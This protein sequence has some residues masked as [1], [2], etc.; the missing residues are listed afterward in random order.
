MSQNNFRG[1]YKITI[2]RKSHDVLINLNSLRMVCKDMSVDF[3]DLQN[4]LSGNPFDSVPAIVYYSILNARFKAKAKGGFMGYE[5]FCAVT[6]DDQ[7]LF[8]QMS[9]MVTEAIGGE[10]KKTEKSK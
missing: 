1:Q 4:F 3:K 8:N 2:A 7:D 5:E 9:E 10:E 6:L